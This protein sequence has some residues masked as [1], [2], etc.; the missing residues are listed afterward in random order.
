M[1]WRGSARSGGCTGGQAAAGELGTQRRREQATAAGELGTRRPVSSARAGSSGALARDG[2]D[3]EG[4]GADEVRAQ[5]VDIPDVEVEAG[6]AVREREQEAGLPPRRLRVA[7]DVG[8]RQHRGRGPGH[9]DGGVGVRGR[10]TRWP[11]G[12]RL[13]RRRLVSLSGTERLG[14]AAGARAEQQRRRVSA[15]RHGGAARG[16]WKARRRGREGRRWCLRGLAAG[17]R[18]GGACERW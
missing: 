4:G 11:C 8:A 14:C 5:G 18:E 9:H 1:W 13:R 15:R 7:E 10:E 6:G 2:G 3:G 16:A 17:A 12:W